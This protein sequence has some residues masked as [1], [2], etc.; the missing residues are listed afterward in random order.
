MRFIKPSLYLTAHLPGLKIFVYVAPLHYILLLF[1]KCI[2]F[3]DRERGR[4]KE[5]ETSVCCSTYLCIYWLILLCPDRD[6]T[7]NLGVSG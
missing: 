6:Q 7:H 5:R 4:Q 1:L 2:D 3:L